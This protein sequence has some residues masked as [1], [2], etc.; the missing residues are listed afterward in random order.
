[1]ATGFDFSPDARAPNSEGRARS[2]RARPTPGRS[3]VRGGWETMQATAV[4][5]KPTE[6]TGLGRI[7]LLEGLP[8]ATLE[9]IARRCAFRRHPA[10][11]TIIQA[12][13]EG[14]D[15]LFVVEGRVRVVTSA[16]PGRE[17]TLA[18]IGAGGHVGELAAI[19]GRPRS[20]SVVALS[21]CRIASLPAA[22]LRELLRG[23]PELALRVLADVVRMVR[24][25]DLK[26]LELATLGAAARLARALLRRAQLAPG[27]RLSVPDVPTQE[28]LAA[29][30]GTTRETVARIIAGL[31]HAGLVHRVHR[32]LELIDPAG[33]RRLAGC[34]DGRPD[35]G[36]PPL[37]E[38]GDRR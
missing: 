2:R 18:E 32:T 17:L 33:L 11:A 22:A 5:E 26:L 36:C 21:D 10:G 13:D 15:L 1:M 27:G 24:E 3:A 19:D 28:A 12:E 25:A 23:S 34:A 37:A 16:G 6:R 8:A 20:A 30:T 9:A 29:E 4:E 7:G 35:P 31:A 14:T 38:T